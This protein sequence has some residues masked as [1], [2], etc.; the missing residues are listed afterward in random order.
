M[1]EQDFLRKEVKRLKWEAGI[2]Y[3]EISQELLCM[4]YRSFLNWLHG[5]ADLG[6]E[7]REILKDYIN[8]IF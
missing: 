5:R 8:C 6:Y 3:R 1:S 2:T 7:K 4:N